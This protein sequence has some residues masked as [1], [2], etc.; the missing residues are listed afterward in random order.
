MAKQETQVE[1]D[2]VLETPVTLGLS[3]TISE[4]PPCAMAKLRD[5]SLR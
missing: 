4:A 3:A 2:A 5:C 1:E